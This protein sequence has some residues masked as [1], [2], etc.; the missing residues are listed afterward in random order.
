MN[1]THTHVQMVPLVLMALINTP[2]NVPPGF[3][4]Q[5]CSTNIDDCSGNPCLNGGT[6]V[7]GINSFSC[8]CIPGHTGS[9]CSVDINECESNQCQNGGTCVDGL[10]SF[11][12]LCAP[13]F[14][15]QNCSTNINECAS[16]PCENG[17]NMHRWSEQ[18]HLHVC[19]R[20]YWLQL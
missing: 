10:N 3:T 9:N 19:V 4:D 5:N 7:D 18:L 2:V 8:T 1:V 17:G 12:C 20:L 15:G 6:C 11:T 14:T 13:G 16:D